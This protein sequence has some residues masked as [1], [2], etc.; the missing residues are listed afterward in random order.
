MCQSNDYYMNYRELFSEDHLK[1]MADMLVINEVDC[2]NALCSSNCSVGIL[3]MMTV[4]L[5][6]W[7][8]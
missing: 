4:K 7:M 5:L 6:L 2:I 3:A 1:W 8:L